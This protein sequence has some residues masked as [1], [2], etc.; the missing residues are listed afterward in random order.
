MKEKKEKGGLPKSTKL[1]SVAERKRKQKE[2]KKKPA[3][4]YL[5]I[6]FLMVALVANVI[7]LL[8]HLGI[9]G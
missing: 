5:A 9:I 7:L 4:D 8:I 2:S 6:L 1:G 3:G